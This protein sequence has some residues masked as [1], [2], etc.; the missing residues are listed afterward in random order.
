MI[1]LTLVT[2]NIDLS[3][4]SVMHC[5]VIIILCNAELR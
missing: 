3:W 5:I 2:Y 1:V 4:L